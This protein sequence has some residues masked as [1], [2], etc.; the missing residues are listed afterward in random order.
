MSVQFFL[1][2]FREINV[3]SVFLCTCQ[4]AENTKFL[5]RASYLEIY[6]E[7]IRDLL[8][9]DSKQRLEVSCCFSKE[10]RL[11]TVQHE[12]PKDLSCLSEITVR[13][14]SQPIACWF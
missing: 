2:S 13:P 5:V 14:V 3:K 12:K 10:I 6:N 1:S 8:G 11:H 9:I 4:C 7:E